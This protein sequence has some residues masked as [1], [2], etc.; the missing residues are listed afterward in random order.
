MLRITARN[1]GVNVVAAVECGIDVSAWKELVDNHFFV[2]DL[3]LKVRAKRNLL[4]LTYSQKE[5]LLDSLIQNDMGPWRNV[6]HEAQ[7]TQLGYAFQEAGTRYQSVKRLMSWGL[8]QTQAETAHDTHGA[9]TYKAPLGR[10]K[11]LL[12]SGSSH[13]IKSALSTN[14]SLPSDHRTVLKLMSWLK[15]QG[16]RGRT[17]FHMRD[18]PKDSTKAL[19]LCAEWGW[20]VVDGELCQLPSHTMLQVGIRRQLERVSRQFFPTYTLQE[21]HF[22]YS[23]YSQ[24]IASHDYTHLQ[25]E[26]TAVVNS[27]ISVLTAWD[28]PSICEFTNQLSG[29]LQILY[30]PAPVVSVYSEAMLAAY[31]ACTE[32][33]TVPLFQLPSDLPDY[34]TIVMTDCNF[35]SLR[36]R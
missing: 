31:K 32:G 6:L 15:D 9:A 34:S 35:L 21:I 1:R 36:R 18:L 3:H 5:E 24:V 4:S 19:Q 2:S 12:S 30:A 33:R 25:D 8:S 11:A 23:R 16:R 17:V 29:T 7:C 14:S 20:M 27:R 22:A 13:Q 26:I 10:M 28:I